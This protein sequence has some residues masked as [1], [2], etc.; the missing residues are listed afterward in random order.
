[1]NADIL[2][3]KWNKIKGQAKKKW[4]KLTDD[5]LDKVEGSRDELVGVIQEKYGK[6]KDAAEKEVDDWESKP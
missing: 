5:D 1:M 6:S 2:K 3:G 4:G